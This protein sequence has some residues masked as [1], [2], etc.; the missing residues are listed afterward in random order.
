MVGLKKHAQEREINNTKFT[1]LDNR[2]VG[3]ATQVIIEI[4]DKE[5]RGNG[6]VDFWGPNKRKECTVL[7][8]KSKEHDER[9]VELV[10]KKVI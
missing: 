2:P 7:I 4:S 5:G 3:G 10:A 1:V 8:K 6:M 9:Y